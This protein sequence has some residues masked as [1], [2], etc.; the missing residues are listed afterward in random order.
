MGKILLL[1]CCVVLFSCTTNKLVKDFDEQTIPES[2]AGLEE[3][4]INEDEDNS[5][6]KFKNAHAKLVYA[7]N[8]IKLG[9]YTQA[10]RIYQEIYDDE[11]YKSDQRDDALY[12]LGNTYES[13][14]YENNDIEKAV[15]YYEL[16]IEV[17][18]LSDKRWD[19]YERSQILRLRLEEREIYKTN[20]STE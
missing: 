1:I 10:I 12:K 15:Y 19:A 9:D 16:L 6:I 8:L 13:V 2:A 7:D 18:P 4:N 11:K 3:F 17:F 14:L 5:L 20:N